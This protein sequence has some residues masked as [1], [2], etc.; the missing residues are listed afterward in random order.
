M[1]HTC[2]IIP[3]NFGS[4]VPSDF[5]N[6]TQG[7]TIDSY[8]LKTLGLPKSMVEKLFRKRQVRVGQMRAKR[9]QILNAHDRVQLPSSVQM[10]TLKEEPRKQDK[11]IKPDVLE[12]LSSSIVYEGADE[13]VLYKPEGLAVQGGTKLTQALDWYLDGHLIRGEKLYIVHRLDQATQGLL[14]IAK[15]LEAARHYGALFQEGKIQKTYL[16][17]TCGIPKSTE[18]EI[19]APLVKGIGD[20]GREN[21]RLASQLDHEGEEKSA[22]TNYQVIKKSLKQNLALVKLYPKTG[23]KHQLRVHLSQVLDTPILGDGRYGGQTRR[24]DARIKTL[25]LAAVGLAFK[26]LKGKPQT[27]EI[28]APEAFMDFF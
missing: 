17:V 21:M 28:P 23:R 19:N 16:A 27:I 3:L 9:D 4:P 22:Q 6:P 26:D 20:Q 7:Q 5:P 15:N 18:G 12:N 10:I 13:L 11:I 14:L 8:L 25:F 24:G 1:I 2:I